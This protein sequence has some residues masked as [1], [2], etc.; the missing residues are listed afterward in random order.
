MQVNVV[1]CANR[2]NCGKFKQEDDML[3]VGLMH[4]QPILINYGLHV[5]LGIY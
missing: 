4:A 5:V 1:G 2:R 3:W